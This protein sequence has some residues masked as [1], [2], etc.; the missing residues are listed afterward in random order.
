MR[1]LGGPEGPDPP[2]DRGSPG[3]LPSGWGI[4]HCS[5]GWLLLPLL[6]LPRRRNRR[7]REKQKGMG[8]NSGGESDVAAAAAL[9][10]GLSLPSGVGQGAGPRGGEQE[11]GAALG[12]GTA[13]HRRPHPADPSGMTGSGAHPGPAPTSRMRRSHRQPSP[14]RTRA[15][16]EM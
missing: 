1:V 11:P 14:H 3:V 12:R 10:P 9:R 13:V 5:Q 7:M 4:I 6:R 2:E 16:W 8:R 15:C